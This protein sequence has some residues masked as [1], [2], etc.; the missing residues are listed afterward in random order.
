MFSSRREGETG[1]QRKETRTNLVDLIE[2]PRRVLQW[3]RHRRTGERHG[4]SSRGE[5]QARRE[6]WRSRP[7]AKRDSKVSSIDFVERADDATHQHSDNLSRVYQSILS[8]RHTISISGSSSSSS[9]SSARHSETDISCCNCSSRLLVH[10]TRLCRRA[11]RSVRRVLLLGLAAEEAGHKR[12][13][14][15][16]RRRVEQRR[17]VGPVPVPTTA[18]KEQEEE[19]QLNGQD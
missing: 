1:N 14:G 11:S 13:A 7:T 6:G 5:G 18:E 15:R 12:R 2:D 3:P 4:P 17:V 10:A 19:K 9:Q 8:A 16:E